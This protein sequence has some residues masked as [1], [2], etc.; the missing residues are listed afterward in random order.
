MGRN[1]K[2]KEPLTAYD[3]AKQR[4]EEKKK[5][6]RHLSSYVVMGVF[7]YMINYLGNVNSGSNRLWFYWPMLGWGVGLAFHYVN[8]FGIPG[9]VEEMSPE[10]EEK[11]IQAELRRLEKKGM[12][13][14]RPTPK[15][16]PP[17]ELREIEKR[18]RESWDDNELV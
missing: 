2:N 1:R 18:K 10:W 16:E 14:S 9:L 17:L 13:I 7:F 8:I 4:V 12:D 6:Y 5:F 11:Q 3:I 15:E